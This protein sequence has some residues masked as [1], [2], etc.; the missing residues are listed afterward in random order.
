MKIL[1]TK[2]IIL[3]EICKE[4]WDADILRGDESFHISI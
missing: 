3:Y 2:C 1:I 4:N